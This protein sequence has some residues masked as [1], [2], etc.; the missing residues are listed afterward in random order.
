MVESVGWDVLV[1]LTRGA[2][3]FESKLTL[4]QCI[5]SRP[6]D[7]L[8]VVGGHGSEEN[9]FQDHAGTDRRWCTR[10]RAG[11]LLGPHGVTGA[12][13]RPARADVSVPGRTETCRFWMGAESVI[14]NG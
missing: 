5:A 9:P 8:A 4:C 6:G 12:A 14:A 7:Q 13:L 3:N 1:H 2:T 10:R 11:K